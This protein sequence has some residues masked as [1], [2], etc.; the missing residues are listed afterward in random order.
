MHDLPRKCAGFVNKMLDKEYKSKWHGPPKEKSA[1]DNY[2]AVTVPGSGLAADF[3]EA[4]VGSVAASLD[5]SVGIG[6]ARDA[7]TD[8]QLL[9][10]T[11]VEGVP[12]QRLEEPRALCNVLFH[13]NQG[14]C[15][16]FI[17]VSF[18]VSFKRQFFLCAH[19]FLE[20]V[21]VPRAWQAQSCRSK[22]PET[23][24]ESNLPP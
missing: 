15:P 7:P 19:L 17:P 11:W 1:N 13:C 4:V 2:G 6:V 24:T 5:E 8:L 16:C 22:H 3:A 14:P 10:R 20:W 12:D 21:G 18:R 23:V 9:A